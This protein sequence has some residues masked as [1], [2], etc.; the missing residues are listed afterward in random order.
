MF[1]SRSTVVMLTCL[2]WATFAGAGAALAAN[3]LANPNFDTG[4]ASWSTLD[5]DLA[6]SSA[7]DVNSCP[8]SGSASPSTPDFVESDWT[9][10]LVS[11]GSCVPVAPG[12][13]VAIRV[14]M[15]P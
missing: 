12:D 9:I 6:W 13:E 7:V 15:K 1:G 8:G 3:G 5:G 2:S 10:T 4:V 14:R 11:S